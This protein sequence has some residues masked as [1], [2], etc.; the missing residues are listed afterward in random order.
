MS[1]PESRAVSVTC[2]RCGGLR[3][4]VRVAGTTELVA[5]KF[6]RKDRSINNLGVGLTGVACTSCG[7]VELYATDP[8]R[9]A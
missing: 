2:E 3:V 6:N 8:D 7:H 9:L 1:E 5:A 4:D